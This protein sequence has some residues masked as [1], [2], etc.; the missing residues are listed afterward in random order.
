MLTDHV[1]SCELLAPTARAK[2]D[3][4]LVGLR[5]GVLG[6]LLLARDLVGLLALDLLLL[7]GTFLKR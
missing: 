3:S 7:E 5:M 4:F 1:L 2:A 6:G